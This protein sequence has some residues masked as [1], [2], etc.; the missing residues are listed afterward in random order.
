MSQSSA[1]A[2]TANSE[3]VSPEGTQEG[4][5]EYL[6]SNTHLAAMLFKLVLDKTLQSPL[7]SKEIKPVTLKGNPP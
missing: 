2:M 1:I 7:E 5:K 3:L 6:P 4:N